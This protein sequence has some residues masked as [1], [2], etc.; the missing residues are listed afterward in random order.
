MA[1]PLGIVIRFA[2]YINLMAL[3]GL[4]LFALYALRGDERLNSAVLPVRAATIGMGMVA[5]AL[6]LLSIVAMTAS[7][8][9]VPLFDVDRGSVSMMINETPMGRAWQVRV[10][11]LLLAVLAGI[12]LTGRAPL[13]RSAV[14]VVAS[15]TALATLA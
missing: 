4:P 1:D 5:L 10:V 8:A 3:F 12:G 7:M 6:S 9:G 15:A 11:A 14:I 13:A 2:L